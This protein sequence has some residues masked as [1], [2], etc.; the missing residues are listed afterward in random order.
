MD[1]MPRA[2]ARSTH[3]ERSPL[4]SR[5]ATV[6]SATANSLGPS[7]RLLL[8][9][10]LDWLGN[11]STCWPSLRTLSRETGLSVRQLQ[12]LLREL[13]QAGWIVLEPRFRPD[14]G[15]TSNVI[16]WTAPPVEYR[17]N[18]PP[19]MTPPP[20]TRTVAP[21][22]PSV[23]EQENTSEN[24]DRKHHDVAPAD[25][26]D[27]VLSSAGQESTAVQRLN[28][29]AA[30]RPR[31]RQSSSERARRWIQFDP[32]R[33]TDGRYAVFMTMQA[34]SFGLL[35]GSESERLAFVACWIEVV[36][37]YRSGKVQ[38]PE[39]ILQHLLRNP[40]HRLPYPSQESEDRAR[41]LLRS[42]SADQ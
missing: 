5:I 1:A 27:V 12:R 26:G 28:V 2:R 38:R 7:A 21:P 16:R 4:V 35:N 23:S 10:L 22:L 37:K 9:T 29:T 15:R 25:A 18:A 39:C 32:A 41:H 6:K 17:E 3:K 36:K 19:K 33:I 13:E 8:R 42:V 20:A 24:S 34:E 30:M 14:G 40:G 11:E 31:R